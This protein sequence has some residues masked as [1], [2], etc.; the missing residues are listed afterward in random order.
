MVS[1]YESVPFGWLFISFCWKNA[2]CERLNMK[3][4]SCPHALLKNQKF[5]DLVGTTKSEK[6]KIKDKNRNFTEVNHWDLEA[7][8][9]IQLQDFL[10]SNLQ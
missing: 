1:S 10:I 6:E 5:K 8:D 9:I 7:E 3:G 2:E 4:M